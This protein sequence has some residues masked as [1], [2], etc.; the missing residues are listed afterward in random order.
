MTMSPDGDV[1]VFS[2]YV[3]DELTRQELLDRLTGPLQD[4]D[5][6]VT[7]MIRMISLA[8]MMIDTDP[9]IRIGRRFDLADDA[10]M[11]SSQPKHTPTSA[12]PFIGQQIIPADQFRRKSPPYDGPNPELAQALVLWRR[13]KAKE[14]DVPPYFILHQRVLY[15]IADS[16]PTNMEELS[17][18]QGIGPKTC[19]RYGE[20]ILNA[21]LNA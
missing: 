6:R 16:W 13:Q 14:M 7:D 5:Y 21:L 18:V 19:E 1:R 8:E 12:M 20:E 11:S 17:H 15:D 4:C 9:E 10:A 2:E 3:G